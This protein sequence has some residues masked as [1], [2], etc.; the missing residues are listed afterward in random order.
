MWSNDTK[1]KYMFIFPQKKLAGKGL[2]DLVHSLG[3]L[4]LQSM[5]LSYFGCTNDTKLRSRAIPAYKK[6]E[7][8]NFEMWNFGYFFLFCKVLHG[9]VK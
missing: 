5:Q 9:E 2:N 8:D 6:D 7:C 1:Y 4:F 3:T